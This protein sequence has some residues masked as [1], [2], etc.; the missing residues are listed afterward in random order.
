MSMTEQE[1]ALGHHEKTKSSNDSGDRGEELY[2]KGTGKIVMTEMTKMT[3]P[4]P[5]LHGPSSLDL[6]PHTGDGSLCS[7]LPINLL[8]PLS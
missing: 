8:S 4:P 1:K 7:I 6:D 5:P 3:T 2:T